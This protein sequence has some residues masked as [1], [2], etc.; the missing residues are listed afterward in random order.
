[1]FNERAKFESASNSPARVTDSPGL[2]S[3]TAS[4]FH[5]AVGENARVSSPPL[6]A[7]VTATPGFISTVVS[8]RH[9]P[10]G[11]TAHHR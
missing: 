3:L 6:F 11:D 2:A 9:E 4:F 10:A 7:A 8:K 5:I 1:M